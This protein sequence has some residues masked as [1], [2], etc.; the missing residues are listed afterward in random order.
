MNWP[1][2]NKEDAEFVLNMNG[3][4]LVKASI[5]LFIQIETIFLLVDI[6]DLLEICKKKI[7]TLSIIKKY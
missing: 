6:V 7:I 2:N 4:H 1:L 3:A 5:G